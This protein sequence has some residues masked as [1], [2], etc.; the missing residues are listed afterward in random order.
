MTVT[1]NISFFHTHYI[2]IHSYICKFVNLELLIKRLQFC[3]ETTAIFA[4]IL[5]FAPDR[6]ISFEIL[7]VPTKERVTT[8]LSMASLFLLFAQ[9]ALC[10]SRFPQL[11]LIFTSLFD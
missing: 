4:A 11:S 7:S 10:R 8:K 1:M 5:A 6:E 3:T 2:F 9:A